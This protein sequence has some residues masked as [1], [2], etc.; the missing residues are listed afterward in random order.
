[1]GRWEGEPVEDVRLCGGVG[2]GVQEVVSGGVGVKNVEV[3]DVWS[4]V[5]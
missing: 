5:D 4:E 1:M 2:E 3:K